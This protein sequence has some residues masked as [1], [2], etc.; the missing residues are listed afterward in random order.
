MIEDMSCGIPVIFATSADP[1]KLHIIQHNE[2]G[3]VV[4]ETSL[5]SATKAAIDLI[6]NPNLRSTFGI[7]GRQRVETYFSVTQMIQKT[8][9][10]YQ[11]LGNR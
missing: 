3:I 2:T 1:S 8:E 11:Q 9:G 5:N 4:S 6:D 10:I 7:A